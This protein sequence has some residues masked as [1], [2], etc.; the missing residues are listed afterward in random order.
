[1]SRKVARENAYKLI[2]EFLFC[3][4]PNDRTKS[5]LASGDMDNADIEYM[6]KAYFG[7]IEHQEELNQI[8]AKYSR[9]F[10]LER[11]YKPDLSALLLALYEIKYMDDIPAAVSINEAVDLVKRYST[12]KSN[13]FVNGI[14]A[15]V[16]KDSVGGNN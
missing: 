12:D 10:D 16:Y 9:G 6:E 5:V 4:M 1:M 8:I 11:I 14:L 15:A 3:G 13:V 2:F 7:V